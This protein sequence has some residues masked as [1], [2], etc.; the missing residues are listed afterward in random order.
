MKAITSLAAFVWLAMATTY[1]AQLEAA[2]PKRKDPEVFPPIELEA[3]VAYCN[4]IVKSG[5]KIEERPFT[6]VGVKAL[7]PSARQA[8]AYKSAL[9]EAAGYDPNRDTPKYIYFMAERAEV[10]ADADSPLDWRPVSN[11]VLAMKSAMAYGA[12]FEEIADDAYLVP[13]VLTAP[14][15]PSPSASSV[16]SLSLHTKIPRREEQNDGNSERIVPTPTEYKMVRF[17]DF[18]ATQGRSYRYRVAVVLEDPNRPLDP[19]AAPDKSV[20]SASVLQR[21]EKVEAE[22]EETYKRIHKRRRTFYIRSEWSQPSDP[23]T[24]DPRGSSIAD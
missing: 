15:P 11:T 17:F 18:S 5:G 1:C 24:V 22:D 8:N 19:N 9:A 2:D 7:V 21:L 20:L 16:E 6:I 13:G 4:V 12:S 10:G 14:I 3:D 23:V